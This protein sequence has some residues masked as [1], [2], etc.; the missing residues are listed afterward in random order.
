MVLFVIDHD[1]FVRQPKLK[2]Y[3]K[4]I[5][6]VGLVTTSKDF[7]PPQSHIKEALPHP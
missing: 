4:G 6:W 1:P 3:W 7:A 5:V 2:A